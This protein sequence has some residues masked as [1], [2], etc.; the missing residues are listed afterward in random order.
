MPRGEMIA[1]KRVLFVMAVEAE[2]G[3]HL[4]ARFDPLMIGVGPVEAALNTGLAL[5]RLDQDGAL[6]ALVVSLGS[7]GSR[8]CT[9]GAVYQV[10]SEEHTSELQ[11]LM[12]TSYAAF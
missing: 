9:L 2:Y 7:A 6:P 11:S 4:R 8:T 10:R 3:P 1:D 5:Q 12:R